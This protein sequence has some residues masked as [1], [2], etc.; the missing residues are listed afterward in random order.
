MT[1]QT[2]IGLIG[3]GEMGSAIGGLLVAGGAHVVTSLQGRSAASAERIR[4]AGVMPVDDL[5]TVAHGSSIVL[6]IVPP[7]EAAHVAAD[8]VQAYG[9]GT[10]APLFV[11]CN[12]LAPA[13][14]I[15]IG[16]TI[17]AAKIRFLDAGII[18]GPPRPN[19]DGPKFYA[20]GPD[21]AE[22]ERLAAY[23]LIV[24]PLAGDIGVASTF[25][26]CYGGISKGLTAIGTAMYALAENAGIRDAFVSEMAVSQ[27]PIHTWL[28]KQM[29]PMYAKAYR[30]V[31]EMQEIAAFGN[32]EP[33]VTDIYDAFAEFYAA[34]AASE[35][36]RVP[37]E[38]PHR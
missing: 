18:G 27:L 29:P 8:F 2:H 11:D 25:K 4:A 16:A 1:T 24:R 13:S 33:G 32:G 38:T 17:T 30:W 34:I 21:I 26:M 12:A 9:D 37:E 35:A 10:N 14:V 31:A 7:G 6:S 15:A 5:A 20:S 22:F 19:V 3:T 23:G 28:T 36:A